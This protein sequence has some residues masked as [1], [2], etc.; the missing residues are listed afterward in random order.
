MKK[1]IIGGLLIII[2]ILLSAFFYSYFNKEPN[3]MAINSISGYV[4]EINNNRIK[5]KIDNR[6]PL[7]DKRE[8]FIY[9][10]YSISK[11]CDFF[12]YAD[13]LKNEEVFQS[14]QNEFNAMLGSFEREHKSTAGLEAP[15]RNVIEKITFKEIKK[16]EEIKI[17]YYNKNQDQIAKKIV[18]LLE[19]KTDPNLFIY[20]K[21]DTELFGRL[22]KINNNAIELALSR[23]NFIFSTSTLG[24]K[25]IQINSDTEIIKKVKKSDSQFKKEQDDFIKNFESDKNNIA[26][27]RYDDKRGGVKDL[28]AGQIITVY[29]SEYKE[30]SEVT[31][32]RI[33]YIIE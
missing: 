13:I 17:N 3:L 20:K 33:E 29:T 32:K 14:E 23:I 2:L 27:S 30:D 4:E 12:R 25:N 7:D 21:G 10:I 1:I 16:G 8:N 28:Q 11:D 5:L 24:F 18:V 31:A 26:P 19:N 15:V 6:S 9:K 22:I